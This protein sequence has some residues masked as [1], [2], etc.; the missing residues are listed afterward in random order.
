MTK[1]E[2]ELI[3]FHKKKTTVRP[4]AR[5]QHVQNTCSVHLYRQNMLSVPLLLSYYTVQLQAQHVH[6][7][8]YAQIRLV[9][10]KHVQE[11]GY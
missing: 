4:N 5:Q 11:F 9:I 2:K 7:P 6:C 1:F 8:I 10:S 3:S